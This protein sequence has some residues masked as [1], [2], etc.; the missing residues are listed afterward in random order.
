MSENSTRSR[1]RRSI[2]LAPM[3]NNEIRPRTGMRRFFR[4]ALY[5][6]GIAVVVIT[7][8]RDQG[9]IGTWRL[10]RTEKQL[11][12]ENEKLRQETVRL[13]NEVHK[14]RTSWDIIEKRA[15]EMGLIYPGEVVIDTRG[16]NNALSGQPKGKGGPGRP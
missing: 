1:A 3:G 15:R 2:K 10:S 4:I 14:L 11:L 6:V 9:V 8:V 16:D 13:Q 12:A 7:L 5:I